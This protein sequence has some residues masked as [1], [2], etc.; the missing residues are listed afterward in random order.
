M[1]PKHN[2]ALFKFQ[3]PHEIFRKNY[4]VFKPLFSSLHL[5][6]DSPSI[7]LFII[8]RISHRE[9]E[10]TGVISWEREWRE[11]KGPRMMLR[12]NQRVMGIASHNVYIL[13]RTGLRTLLALNKQTKVSA[14]A[15]DWR[16]V[17]QY[18]YRWMHFQLDVKIS[19]KYRT[20]NRHSGSWE[21]RSGFT[22]NILRNL[23]LKKLVSDF[24]PSFNA[25]PVSGALQRATP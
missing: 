4:P 22:T 17:G 18:R 3:N 20:G 9:G 23:T 25:A 13:S 2:A 7:D 8:K 19:Q 11:G 12:G 14:C 21:F 10:L 1:L 15:P 24:T 5:S 6:N 16:L